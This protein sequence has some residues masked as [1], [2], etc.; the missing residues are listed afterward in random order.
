MQH[1]I[2]LPAADFRQALSSALLYVGGLAGGPL[3]FICLHYQ[4][5]TL[6]ATI[7]ALDGHGFYQQTLRV[8]QAEPSPEYSL[9]R[10]ENI[11]SDYGQLLI[12]QDAAKA[13]S[14]FIPKNAKGSILLEIELKPSPKPGVA[15]YHETRC[16]YGSSS[17]YTFHGVIQDFPD[18]RKFVTVALTNKD[19]ANIPQ[20]RVFPAR[21]FARIGKALASGDF[22]HTYWAKS[23][24]GPCLLEY[25]ENIR[26]VYMPGKWHTT[27]D[28]RDIH[29][30]QS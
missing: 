1:T 8:A 18:Y 30:Q 27:Y 15:A 12:P 28:T 26:I 29:E 9:P 10:G 16:T 11:F 19:E 5:K 14:K 17:S 2:T 20:G 22:F 24:D 6:A 4:E 3:A 21:E 23:Q 7:N 25:G 13:L